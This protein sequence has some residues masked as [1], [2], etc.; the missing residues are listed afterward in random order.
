M[1]ATNISTK[2]LGSEYLQSGNGTPT[3]SNSSLFVDAQNS[4]LYKK[5][6]TYN[7]WIPVRSQNDGYV[8]LQNNS[9]TINCS[10]SYPTWYSLTSLTW[11]FSSNT[12]SLSANS[13]GVLTILP[14]QSGKYFVEIAST[15]KY[16]ATSGT[17][18][19]GL[20][21][22]G[23]IPTSKFVGYTYV[24]SSKNSNGICFS[25]Y[26]N[27]SEGDNLRL[28]ISRLSTVGTITLKHASLYAE[29]SLI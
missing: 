11:G 14:G 19:V 24:S 12:L 28:L 20:S 27:L 7:N 3:H 26:I 8:F 25:G 22:N 16:V 13:S 21:L 29:K 4:A 5:E 18:D 23:A 2:T 1:A 6:T 17:I 15:V 9:T 10:A